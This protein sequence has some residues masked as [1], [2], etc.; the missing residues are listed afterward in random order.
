[1]TSL[2]LGRV[3]VEIDLSDIESEIEDYVC[4]TVAKQIAEW[5]EEY[6]PPE[7]DLSDVE[8]DISLLQNKVKSLEL[9]IKELID[10]SKRQSKFCST[11]STIN[12]N[13]SKRY[14]ATKNVYG[15]SVAFLRSKIQGLVRRTPHD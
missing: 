6:S 15:K 1:M 8:D 12:E 11:I 10:A 9:Q 13:V 2:S 14:A 3:N 7:P 5:E 4:D